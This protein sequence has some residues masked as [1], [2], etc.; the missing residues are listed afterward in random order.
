MAPQANKNCL[1]SGWQV[2]L[3][4]GSA[5][6]VQ[7]FDK[8]VLATIAFES[9]WGTARLLVD[10]RDKLIRKRWGRNPLRMRW[11]TEEWQQAKGTQHDVVV[12]S[13]SGKSFKLQ[14]PARS[15]IANVKAAVE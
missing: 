8:E 9:E 1:Q 2:W 7:Q 11:L 5:I 4:K 13:L 3:A 6:V 15:T 10:P 12:Q 14:M